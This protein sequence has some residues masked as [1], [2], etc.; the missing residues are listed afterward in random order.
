MIIFA[1][2][3]VNQ[4]VI[5]ALGSEGFKVIS[6]YDS[7]LISAPDNVIFNH[8]V[9]H[10]YVLLTF[11][12]DFGNITRFNIRGSAGV[13]IVYVEDMNKEEIIDRA[14]NLFAKFHP[15]RFKGKLLIIERERVRIWPK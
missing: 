10:H 11:D 4:D 15:T 5:T 7:K 14:L 6:V 13:V 8:C 12:K 3:C 2:Q 9:T 1:D